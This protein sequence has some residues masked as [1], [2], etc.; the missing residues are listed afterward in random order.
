M[1]KLERVALVGFGYWGEK[2]ARVLNELGVLDAIIDTSD[3]RLFRAQ[4]SFPQIINYGYSFSHFN[5]EAIVIAAPPE[6]HYEIAKN[7]LNAGLHVFVEKPAAT[8][9]IEVRELVSLASQ[10]NLSF[11]VGY[12][13]A[14]SK[15]LMEMP[16][17]VGSAD[18]FIKLLNDKGPPSGSPRDLRW[19]ALPHAAFIAYHILNDQPVKVENYREENR[20]EV[21]MEFFNG[22]KVF[23]DVGDWTGTRVRSVELR[24]CHNRYLFNAD[25]P[26]HLLSFGPGRHGYVGTKYSFYQDGEG[27]PLSRELKDFIENDNIDSNIVPVS[28]LLERMITGWTGRRS[29]VS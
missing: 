9:V 7:C 26:D 8:K 14:Y 11:K 21:K 20:F 4:S 18:L 15:G 13:Y 22:S 23:I 16:R 1:K 2:I 10:K 25:Q 6:T 29:W 24:E 12:I 28:E 19:A 17:P 3:E 5:V 27:D